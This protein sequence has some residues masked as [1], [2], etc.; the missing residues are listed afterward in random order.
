EYP[1]RCTLCSIRPKG[2]ISGVRRISGVRG[3]ER[4]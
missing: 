1:G 4:G 2:E 3:E